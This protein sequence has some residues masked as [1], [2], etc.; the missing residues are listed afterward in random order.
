MPLASLRM[1]RT[2]PKALN[3]DVGEYVDFGDVLNLSELSIFLWIYL[4]YQVSS[5]FQIGKNYTWSDIN[6]YR[7]SIDFHYSQYIF[8][9][10]DGT[11]YYTHRSRY[12]TLVFDRWHLTGVML[13]N[14][15][16]KIILNE[17]IMVDEEETHTIAPST[18]HLLVNQRGAMDLKAK[19]K[20]AFLYIYDRP[21][22][23]EE[24][25]QIYKTPLNPPTNG[26]KL[27]VDYTSI[28]NGLW[29]DRSGY[30]N[31][32][33]IYGATEEIIIKSPVR[34]LNRVRLLNAV[35]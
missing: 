31:H 33:T 1:L 25:L 35:R 11:A 22:P 13:D 20:I 3:F 9:F 5:A 23:S 6:G 21:L 19:V 24:W 30:G 10:G 34:K 27:W 2:F 17:N 7:F 16:C 15:R 8:R 28:S 32:G 14:G 26:L 12:N 18:E 4:P 29:L